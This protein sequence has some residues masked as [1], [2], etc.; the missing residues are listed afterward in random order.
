MDG[1][2]TVEN[3]DTSLAEGLMLLTPFAADA[4]DEATQ[5]FVA[6]YKE[7]YNETPNQF[8]ADGYDAIYAIKAALEKAEATPDMSA[9]DICDAMK[10]A[11]TEVT[12]QGLTGGE[13]G[14]T[15]EATGEVSKAPKAVKIENGVYVGM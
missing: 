15:W 8:A 2:L 4:E 6:T 13:E 9:S 1:I 3:F 12:V 11:I 5:K 14:L 10:T 7:K